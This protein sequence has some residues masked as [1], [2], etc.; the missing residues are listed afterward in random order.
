MPK[1]LRSLPQSKCRVTRQAIRDGAPVAVQRGA[2]ASRF[3]VS[4]WLGIML[5]FE[6]GQLNRIKRSFANLRD[7]RSDGVD[8][9]RNIDDG[10][11][12]RGEGLNRCASAEP[13]QN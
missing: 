13:L 2:A 4:L 6:W 5:S 10:L 12:Q 1:L 7:V 3:P 9:G 8:S 11:E